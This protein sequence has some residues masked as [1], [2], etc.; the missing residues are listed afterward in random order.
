MSDN[1]QVYKAWPY[2]EAAQIDEKIERELKR[3]V[4]RRG[5]KVLLQTGFGPSGLPHIG[6]FSEVARTSW[7][8]RAYEAMHRAEGERVETELYVFSDDMDG[9]RSVPLDMPDPEALKAHFGKP[10][11]EVPDPFGEQESFAARMNTQLKEFL[12]SF[13]FEYTF[14]SS[15][16][17]YKSGAFNPGLLKVMEHYEAIRELV[18][19]TLSEENR[20]SWSPFLPICE[21]CGRV[22]TT[23]VVSVDLEQATVSYVCDRRVKGKILSWEPRPRAKRKQESSTAP[24]YYE[25]RVNVDG[26]R[27]EATTSVCDGR[28]KAGWKVDW[29]MRW[30]VFGVDYEMYGK[31]LIASAELSSQIARLMGAEPPVGMCYEW[32]NDEFGRSISKTKGNGLSIEEWL[33]YGPLESLAWYV[34]QNPTKA[35]KLYFGVIPQSTDRFL[36]DRQ[37]YGQSEPG[38]R[39]NNAVHFAEA[40]KIEGGEEVGYQSEI[41]FGVLLNLVSVLNTEDRAMIW[42]YIL[43]YDA[44]AR[45]NEGILEAM[46]TNALHY[47]RDFVAPTKRYVMVPEAM[48]PALDELRAFLG[49]AEGQSAEAIQAAV[50][51]AGKDH[52]H[53]LPEWFKALYQLLLG[54]ERGPR[55]GTFFELYGIKDSLKLIDEQLEAVGQGQDGA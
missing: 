38:E 24:E 25:E 33:T 6:T 9:M 15:Q 47:Y 20:E 27:H 31:D 19:S 13:G 37:R 5:D 12:D 46:I 28:V 32:F 51:A 48:R 17:H 3:G 41:T 49:R 7:V 44:E 40:D 45:Q 4:T 23:R 2:R 21:R 35:K 53:K 26:C 22:T 36:K 1:E 43:R 30:V 50:Y 54:Q 42:D 29:A 14:R 10:L 39:L 16:E 52:G 34:F 8:R 11:C 55:L 18:A